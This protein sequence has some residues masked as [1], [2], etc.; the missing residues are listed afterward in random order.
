MTSRR[1]QAV[2]GLREH[3]IT[4]SHGRCGVH[5][6]AVARQATDDDRDLSMLCDNIDAWKDF[7]M[8]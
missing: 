6:P 7:G 5:L 3:E 4:M 2:S 8:K 1:R